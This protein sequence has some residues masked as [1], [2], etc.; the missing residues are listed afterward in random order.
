[1]API[2]VVL[3][4]LYQCTELELF[5]VIHVSTN[6]Y[7]LHLVSSS[8]RRYYVNAQIFFFL[9]QILRRLIK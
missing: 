5:L 6:S 8:G 1:M 9:L 7:R 2:T 4:S 3:D